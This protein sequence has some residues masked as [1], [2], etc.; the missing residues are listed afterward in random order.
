M[1]ARVT[2]TTRRL[3]LRGCAGVVVALARTSIA[4]AQAFPERP[5]RLIV[6]FG[7][8][9]PTDILARVLA[10][11]LTESLGRQVIVENKAGASGNIATQAVA[12][13]APDGY[14]FLIGASPIVINEMLFPDL[15]VKFGRDFVAV[16]PLGT[17]ENVLVVHP[18]LGVRDLA[19]FVRLAREHPN[20]VT[21]ATL[22]VSSFSHLAARAFEMRAGIAM[23]PIAYRGAGDAARDLLSGRVQA[24]F[25]SIPAVIDFI[26]T[27]QLVALATTGPKR[28][29]WLP[30]VPTIAESGFPGFDVRLWVG[31]FAPV[32]VDQERLTTIE[33]AVAAAMSS[34]AMQHAM[35]AQGIAPLAM[36]RT[37]FNRF[38]AAEVDRWKA[39]VHAM[40][41]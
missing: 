41:N 16:A 3:F 34:S 4:R 30:Y 12:A 32:G 10:R 21:Y 7:A 25:A 39:V 19:G 37:D 28:T 20:G 15:P 1:A 35:D 11:D 23:A 29:H 6:G 40:K 17:T 33:A 22:G 13:A 14:T 18:S 8:G 38:V 9:G 26:R 2:K 31:V 36:S 24:R 27:G 5:V